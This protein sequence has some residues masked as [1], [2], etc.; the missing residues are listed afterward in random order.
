M[1]APGCGPLVP[2]RLNRDDQLGEGVLHSVEEPHPGRSVRRAHQRWI[3]SSMPLHFHSKM[4]ENKQ[5][6]QLNK[7]KKS[8][9]ARGI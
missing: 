3:T 4:L 1:L 5:S 8:N 7:E 2:A 6:T 9:P